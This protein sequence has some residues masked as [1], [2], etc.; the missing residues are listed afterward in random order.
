[1]I[2]S[3]GESPPTPSLVYAHYSLS[4]I[5]CSGPH[6]PQCAPWSSPFLKQD[7]PCPPLLSLSFSTPTG[8]GT[9][10]CL[11]LCRVPPIQVL[12][13][14]IFAT[15]L[16]ASV[17]THILQREIEVQNSHLDRD[18]SNECVLGVGVHPCGCHTPLILQQY[19]QEWKWPW[20]MLC[21]FSAC[22]RVCMCAHLCL[23]RHVHEGQRCLSCFFLSSFPPCFLR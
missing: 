13:H 19:S 2:L 17:V 3:F 21:F 8:P 15:A 4:L 14:L 12:V 7:H 20:R 22:M 16:Q 9:L 23:G 1:M 6:P 11:S 10:W 18:V 5:F